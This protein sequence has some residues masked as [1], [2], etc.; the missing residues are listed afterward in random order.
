ML[1]YHHRPDV[2]KTDSTDPDLM[3]CQDS[4]QLQ[5]EAFW[6]IDNNAPSYCQYSPGGE[7]TA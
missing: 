3:Q 4:W 6:I 2:S 1:K 5:F 7:D